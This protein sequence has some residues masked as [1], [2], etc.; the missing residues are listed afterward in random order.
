MP[1]FNIDFEVYC[2]TCGAGLCQ[3]TE[4][5]K[6]REREQLCIRINACSCCV[7]GARDEGYDDGLGDAASESEAKIEGLEAEVEALT[8]QVNTLSATI[9][10]HHNPSLP[11]I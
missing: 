6:T 10:A 8:T 5:T 3:N 11:G 2:E 4:V 9:F 1:E 7:E